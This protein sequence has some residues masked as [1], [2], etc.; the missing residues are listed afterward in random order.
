M[1]LAKQVVSEDC[2]LPNPLV[3]L[4][5]LSQFLKGN[6]SRGLFLLLKHRVLL[7]HPE[8]SMSYNCLVI[9]HSQFSRSIL[10]C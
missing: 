5:E 3:I 4:C 9:F 8:H 1:T 7:K 2:M 10:L 6:G